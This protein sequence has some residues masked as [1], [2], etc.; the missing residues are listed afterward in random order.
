MVYVS[1]VFHKKKLDSKKIN[2]KTIYISEGEK[3]ER[4]TNG[5]KDDNIIN[6]VRIKK[7]YYLNN[8]LKHIESD[9]D[10]RI[11]YTFVEN[12]NN[13]KN[14]T[15]PNCGMTAKL[16][17]FN[18]GCPY[19]GTY[20]NLDYS[21]VDLGSKKYYDRILRNKTYMVLYYL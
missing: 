13:N 12:T 3:F 4:N 2:I 19:C 5:S 6:G 7:E 8:E 11:E 20:Y 14:Y 17:E 18:G 15:C 16:K 1:D 10:T 9:F 21:D